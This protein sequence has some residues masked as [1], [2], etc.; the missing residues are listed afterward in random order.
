MLQE[1][2]YENVGK[3]K[4]DNYIIY[5]LLRNQTE[6][7]KGRQVGGG[8]ALGCIK[9]LKPAW[10]RDGG[11]ETEALSINIHI[12]NMIIRCCV[13]YGP[14][15]SDHINKKELF[16]NYLNEEVSFASAEGAG[17][18]LQMDGNLWAGPGIIDGDPRHQNKNGRMF[19][20]F[21]KQNNLT[22]VNSLPVVN[23]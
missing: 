19:E 18:I 1:T 21:L 17:F 2:K 23:V 12:K 20:M 4:I 6:N 13:A 10:V 9:E 8:L 15:E 11:Q 22:V 7:K 14:Q 5:E 3:L 16:W